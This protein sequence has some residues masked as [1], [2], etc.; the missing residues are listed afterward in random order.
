MEPDNKVP[1]GKKTGEIPK[2]TS[3]HII[4]KTGG[5]QPSICDAKLI[6]QFFN[7]NLAKSWAMKDG[8]IPKFK[9]YYDGEIVFDII[10]DPRFKGND[11][12][13][14]KF[15]AEQYKINVTL[16]KDATSYQAY[17]FKAKDI[18]GYLV[19]PS[20]NSEV[21]S[22]LETRMINSYKNLPSEPSLIHYGS[23]IKNQSQ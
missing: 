10:S 5:E 18:I 6:N 13:L 12:L 17:H 4:H 14:S 20:S 21:I 3:L 2:T 9:S 1:D 7:G 8:F 15:I 23:L 22:E 11:F 16:L 19:E